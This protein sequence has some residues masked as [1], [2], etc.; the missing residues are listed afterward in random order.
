MAITWQIQE[1]ETKEILASYDLLKSQELFFEAAEPYV[2]YSG[3]LGSGKTLGLVLKGIDMSLKYPGNFGL[4]GRKTY[5]EL[6]DSVIKTFFEVVEGEQYRHLI[7]GYS[8]AEARVKFTN[9]SEIVFRHLDDEAQSQLKSMNLGWAGIDQMEDI[10]EE[11]FITLQGRLR[12]IGIP[13]QIFGTCNPSLSWLFK[14]FNQS[15]DPHYRLIEASTLEN[16]HL[17]DDY[18][19][20]LMEYPESLKKSLVYGIWDESLLAEKAVFPIEYIE[21]QL[22][23]IKEPKKTIE[24]LKIYAEPIPKGVYQIGVDPSEGIGQDPASVH[25]VSAANFEVVAK[26]RGQ[27]EPAELAQKACEIAEFYNNARIVPEIN[28]VGLALLSKLKEIYYHI[29]KR[30]EFDKKFKQEIE[31]IGWKTTSLTKPILISG[32][33]QAMREKKL[34]IYDK[35]TVA[36]LKTFIRSPEASKKGMGA[37]IGFHDDDVI[38]LGLAL[39]DL[40]KIVVPLQ[41]TV[42]RPN[43][44]NA[45]NYNLNNQRPDYFRDL[46]FEKEYSGIETL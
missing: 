28:G 34:K 46:I 2:L 17:P 7:S 23:L 35:E 27:M 3:G 15:G 24:G 36:Q 21:A 40:S 1:N 45:I 31:K 6:Q 19:R 8:K 10:P 39:I 12:R 41:S 14:R 29:Y 37:E 33:L 22:R 18:I 44:M 11:T 43:K 5:R 30:K 9:G 16:Y 38:S 32:I 4:L 25:V 13:H 42:E 20:R 26:W